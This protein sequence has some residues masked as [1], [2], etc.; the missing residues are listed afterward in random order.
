[1]SAP[2]AGLAGPDSKHSDHEDRRAGPNNVAGRADS[3]A[4]RRRGGKTPERSP[5]SGPAVLTEAAAAAAGLE[6]SA[7]V[8]WRIA[9]AP[10]GTG[11]DPVSSWCRQRH[12]RRTLAGGLA[13]S[14]GAGACRRPLTAAAEAAAAAAVLMAGLTGVPGGH[15]RCGQAAGGLVVTVGWVDSVAGRRRGGSRAGLTSPR[16]RKRDRQNTTL[17]GERMTASDSSD[18]KELYRKTT[19]SYP[20]LHELWPARPGVPC[21]S[22][23][24]GDTRGVVEVSELPQLHQRSSAKR[25]MCI[26]V[27]P[28]AAGVK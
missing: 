24:R 21:V 6:L 11:R 10:T 26:I 19:H 13:G 12:Q 25:I 5:A 22:G 1:M 4:G 3:V 2:M 8:R 27:D 7:G 15:I 17:G 16:R 18:T 9:A 23:N 28:P 14:D 20:G